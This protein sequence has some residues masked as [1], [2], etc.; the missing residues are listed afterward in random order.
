MSYVSIQIL[1]YK[2]NKQKSRKNQFSCTKPFTKLGDG[3]SNLFWDI[4]RFRGWRRTSTDECQELK[5]RPEN[6]STRRET[7]TP[8]KPFCHLWW[9]SYQIKISPSNALKHSSIYQNSKLILFQ[10][11]KPIIT[12]FEYPFSNIIRTHLSKPFIYFFFFYQNFYTL[13][14]IRKLNRLKKQTRFNV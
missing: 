3:E 8:V 14:L 1:L 11:S 10:N 13:K 4:G 12:F 6:G 5:F 7:C 9:T 2:Q